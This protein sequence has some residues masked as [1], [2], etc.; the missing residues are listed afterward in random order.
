M[1]LTGHHF[2]QEWRRAGFRGT[3]KAMVLVGQSAPVDLIQPAHE[4]RPIHRWQ[5]ARKS[6]LANGFHVTM[7]RRC[8]A[9]VKVALD[10]DD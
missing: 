2:Q 8:Y 10:F 6:R 5:A 1:P 4:S 9:V 3:N 7:P